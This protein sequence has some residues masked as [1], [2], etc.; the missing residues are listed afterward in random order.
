MKQFYGMKIP[1][2]LLGITAL[3]VLLVSCGNP[4]VRDITDHLV[5]KKEEEKNKNNTTATTTVDGLAEYLATL[6]GPGPHTIK[7]NDVT[8]NNIS[9]VSNKIFSALK[10]VN[11]DLSG[12]TI[13]NIPDNVFSYCSYL[14]GITIPA[15]VTTIGQEA[16][17]SCTKLTSVTFEGSISSIDPNAFDGNLISVYSGP[18]TYKLISGTWAKTS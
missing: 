14:T 9:D 15:S 5:K 18:G 1:F 10:Y 8:V 2:R 6:T 4:W 11:L 12:S 17:M 16:F 3:V 13:P 7:L